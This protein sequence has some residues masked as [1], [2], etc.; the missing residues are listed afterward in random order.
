MSHM[1]AVRKADEIT[2][3]GRVGCLH[4]P[5]LTPTHR[6]RVVLGKVG[7]GH[8][9]S[10]KKQQKQQYLHKQSKSCTPHTQPRSSH[11]LNLKK[12]P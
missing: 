3:Q 6:R 4:R 10:S 8:S 9:S 7:R 12:D 11:I 2:L 5:C 1:M